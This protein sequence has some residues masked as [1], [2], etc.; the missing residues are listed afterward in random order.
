MIA[1]ALC[2]TLGGCG[3][4]SAATSGESSTESGSGTTEAATT[5][6]TTG[7]STSA[8]TTMSGG[9]MS[10]S[11]GSTTVDP[12]T[13]TAT[14]TTTTTGT[15][16]TTATTTDPTTTGVDDTGPM[17]TEPM[18]TTGDLTTGDPTG[19]TGEGPCVNNGDCQDPNLPVCDAESGECVECTPQS[20]VCPLSSYCSD[21]NT[22]VDGCLGPADCPAQTVCDVDNN[23]CVAN[24]V[25][26]LQL[27]TWG[28]DKDGDYEIDPDLDGPIPPFT[29][30]C[31]QTT[32]GGGWTEITLDIACDPL[33]AVM[34]PVEAAPISG[35]DAMCRPYTQDAAGS[36][37]YHY[38]VPFPP[39]FGELYLQDYKAKANGSNASNTAD[40]YPSNF[41][42]TL[43]SL[44][45]KAGGTGDISFGSADEAG[46]VI[47]FAATLAND[48][49]CWD[50]EL[51]WLPGA[52]I[53]AVQPDSK[54]LRIGWGEAGG[55]AEGWYP[56]WAGTIRI[57]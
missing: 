46:P 45:N 38:T 26:C 44:A 33:S 55:Q 22:C 16:T 48:F 47:S 12:T 17:T 11:D 4:D 29:T 15:E 35:L 37:T 1:G 10:M 6:T 23:V 24:A 36:H 54:G 25:S 27:L 51:D 19:T 56:W 18:T 5:T 49:D 8:S 7:A 50:C 13:T 57:R 3:D 39:G 9:S 43:W 2:L 20:D 21:A 14:T 40:C 34:T 42:Q 52:M 32:D 28:Y 31:D 41:N 30:Y 53:Y